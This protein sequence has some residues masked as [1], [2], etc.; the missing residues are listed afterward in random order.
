MKSKDVPILNT[1][2]A[3]NRQKVIKIEDSKSMSYVTTS[4]LIDH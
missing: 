1:T 4:I 2:D 3:F